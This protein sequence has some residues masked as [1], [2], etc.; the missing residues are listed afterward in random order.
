MR[1][2][3]AA[4]AWVAGIFSAAAWTL[5]VVYW[6]LWGLFALAGVLLARCWRFLFVGLLL[7]SLGG[8]RW[9]AMP[10]PALLATYVP[11]GSVALIGEI[12][13]S[14]D[15][16]D[17]K[18]LVTLRAHSLYD[19]FWQATDGL[20]LVTLA[21]TEALRVGD[22]IQVGGALRFPQTGDRFNYADFL[23]RRGVYRL[24][25]V[26]TWQLVAPAPAHAAQVLERWRLDA[27]A[28]IAAHLPEPY[29]GLLTGILLGNER[30]IAPSLQ[31]AFSRT[32]AAHIIAISGY[33][34]AVLSGLMMALLGRAFGQSWRTVL[35]AVLLTGGYTLFVGAN[36][37]VLRAWLM[38][39]LLLA[40]PLFKRRVYLPASLAFVAIVFSLWHPPLL[41]DVSFQ[42]SFMAVLGIALFLQPL[43]RAY[44]VWRMRTRSALLR[45]VLGALRE[46]LVVTVAVQITVLPLLVL[47]FERVSLVVLWVN[48]LLAPVQ[49]MILLLGGAA[50]LVSFALPTLGQLLFW[51]VLLPL[52]WSIAVVRWFAALPLAEVVAAV[53][54]R[55]VGLCYGMIFGGSVM[56]GLKP[57]ALAV[58]ARAL[59]G[60]PVRYALRLAAVTVLL[61]LAAAWRSVPDGKLHV[62]WLD[63]GHSHAVLIQTPQGAHVLVDGGRYPA[64]L[65]TALGDRLPFYKRTLD[66]LVLTHP[67]DQDNA[68]LLEVLERYRAAAVLTNG[69]PQLGET[70]TRLAQLLADVPT[71]TA[72]TGYEAVFSDGVRLEVL[73]PSAPPELGAPLGDGAM[74]LRLHYGAHSV[75]LTSDITRSGQAALLEHAYP[76]ADVMSVP[77]HGTARALLPEFWAQVQPRYVV[78]QSDRTNGRGDPDADTLAL[79]GDL[80]L[81]RTDQDGTLHLS[82]DGERVWVWRTP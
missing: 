5:P 67:D 64:R 31:E 13:A 50:V 15:V 56:L 82:S 71:V 51:G 40:A 38:S 1:L 62:W 70:Q 8:L 57:D 66:L 26:A 24:M 78:L 43:E 25:P 33:N 77:Q 41:W 68:A 72:R 60:Q 21:R 35:L 9:H 7:F 44:E 34:M 75:L 80:P 73:H 47:Y 58:L 45:G 65:L 53:D 36:A 11:R 59:L 42:L 14:P 32:G 29:A 2:A 69:Q 12:V 81:W 55:L 63:V 19:G 76:L 20:V 28:R 37:A 46:P 27:Q 17:D 22:I 23:A 49:A 30:G 39:A 6:L 52:A 16:R 48:V 3:A 61:L 54:P 79:L 4:L 18:T 10:P 74:V